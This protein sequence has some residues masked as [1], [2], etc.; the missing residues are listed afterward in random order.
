MHI[1]KSSAGSP[2]FFMLKKLDYRLFDFTK[3]F[4]NN[5]SVCL[6]NFNLKYN[7]LLSFPGN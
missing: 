1:Q 4:T 5:T 2:G 6:L 3:E 7:L